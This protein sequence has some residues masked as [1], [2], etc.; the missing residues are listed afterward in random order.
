MSSV[1]KL[2]AAK[3]V[4][5]SDRSPFSSPDRTPWAAAL[6]SPESLMGPTAFGNV[7]GDIIRGRLRPLREASTDRSVCLFG[8]AADRPCA[9]VPDDA[10]LVVRVL[11]G[12]PRKALAAEMGIALSTATGRFLRALDKLG[13]GGRNIPLPLVLA[14][15]SWAGADVIPTARTAWFDYEGAHCLALSV[16]RPSTE[17]LAV[18]TRGQQEVALWLIE[19]MTR[20]EIANLRRTSVH[21]VARQ[22]HSIYN[23]LRVTVA[24]SS[25]AASWNSI[26]SANLAG[27]I[28]RS[29]SLEG[30]TFRPL[31]RRR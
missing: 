4:E 6:D 14:A 19:G 26:A 21:T 30:L 16:P 5:S 18:L 10:S 9:L 24:T 25:F 7:W 23:T 1:P 11:C 15:Q 27:R 8:Q 29:A 3:A 17:R 13:L 22:F 28:R 2:I 31:R 12:E 20:Y